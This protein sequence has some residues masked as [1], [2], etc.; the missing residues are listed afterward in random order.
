MKTR[1]I[2]RDYPITLTATVN[3]IL[4]IFSTAFL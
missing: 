1:E 2:V 3:S 4:A